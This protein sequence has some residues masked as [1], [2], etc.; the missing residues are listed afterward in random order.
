M[1]P[2]WLTLLSLAALMAPYGPPGSASPP[3]AADPL[4]SLPSRL[5][6]SDLAVP[7]PVAQSEP[8]LEIRSV[9]ALPGLQFRLFR[10]CSLYLP[11]GRSAAEYCFSGE[12]PEPEQWSF[13]ADEQG[14]A[15]LRG[16]E[17]GLYHLQVA[18]W[19]SPEGREKAEF[20]RWEDDVFTAERAIVLTSNVQLAVG[21]NLHRQVRLEFRDLAGET[22]PVSRVSSVIVRSSLG[23]FLTL[24]GEGRH[25]I[26]AERSLRR[27]TGLESVPVVYAVQRVAVDGG[28]VVNRGQ[29]RLMAEDATDSW[30][31]PLLLYAARFEPRDA[32]FGGPV[33]GK[34]VLEFP[35]GRR[36]EVSTNADRTA[37]VSD[38]ARG[39]Y[40][41]WV[42]SGPQ[43]VVPTIMVLS[44]DQLVRPPVIT[45]LDIGAVLGGG[46]GLFLG[47]LFFGR[48]HLLPWARRP[49]AGQ[50]DPAASRAAPPDE[51]P[52]A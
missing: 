34:V 10:P 5:I 28:N 49:S 32:L 7:Q 46:M 21:M 2:W 15:R 47:L 48:P 38:L 11:P 17:P 27:D 40:R 44:R 45:Y 4:G 13:T 52:S 36:L 19:E 9:P 8:S 16:P 23:T 3:M 18:S 35:D 30:T 1:A 39:T 31:L 41:V 50:T 26:L 22:I 25:W 29:L 20:S 42:V 12:I 33:A 51:E 24:E 37:E 14:V 6:E 43:I